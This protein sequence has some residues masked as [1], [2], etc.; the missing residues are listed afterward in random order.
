MKPCTLVLAISLAL[1]AG[2]NRNTTTPPSPKTDSSSIVPQAAAGSTATP[3]NAGTPSTS[4]RREGSNP[5]QG[6]VDPKDAAQRRDFGSNDDRAGPQ[7]SDA[8][9]TVR[10]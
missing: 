10:N 5:T 9:P 4:E 7:S 1:V 6:Q 3:A 2:C 8:K